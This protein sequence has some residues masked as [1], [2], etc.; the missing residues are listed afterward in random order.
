[1][2]NGARVE[3]YANA[4]QALCIFL[5]PNRDEA[6]IQIQRTTL[7]IDGARELWVW[8]KACESQAWGTVPLAGGSGP[9]IRDCYHAGG[10]LA[11]EGDGGRCTRELGTGLSWGRGR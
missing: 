11:Q 10:L 9:D 7:L 2:G 1:M 5:L 3:P 6:R 8:E 4:A